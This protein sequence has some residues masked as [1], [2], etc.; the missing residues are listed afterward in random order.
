MFSIELV[1][2]FNS[3]QDL[4]PPFKYPLILSNPTLDNLVMASS[5]LP[6]GAKSIKGFSISSSNYPTHGAN[7]PSRPIKIEPGI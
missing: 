5:S 3:I 1:C 2:L 4:I 7:L 6:S